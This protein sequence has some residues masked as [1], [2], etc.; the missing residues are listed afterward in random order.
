MP[1]KTKLNRSNLKS[2]L[3]SYAGVKPRVFNLPRC[4]NARLENNLDANGAPF[5]T[6]RAI[7]FHFH[8][9]ERACSGEKLFLVCRLLSS[10]EILKNSLE[11]VTREENAL[12]RRLLLSWP[13]GPFINY[14]SRV[15]VNAATR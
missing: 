14:S 8:G 3:L 2:P 15:F 6:I 4:D 1:R 7:P 13:Q 5:Y 9:R 11:G 10:S 12:S